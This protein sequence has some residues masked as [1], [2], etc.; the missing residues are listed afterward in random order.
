MHRS[1]IFGLGA[2]PNIARWQP[3]PLPLTLT[4]YP[5]LTPGSGGNFF[6]AKMTA[7]DDLTIDCSNLVAKTSVLAGPV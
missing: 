1:N 5:T 6:S 3:P 7:K 2:K 4:A